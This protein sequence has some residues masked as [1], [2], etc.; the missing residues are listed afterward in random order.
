MLI[1]IE[2][3]HEN[4]LKKY[5]L[6]GRSNVMSQS[7]SY[8]ERI[9]IELL[10]QEGYSLIRI[11]ERL[12]R[13]R[14]SITREIRRGTADNKKDNL[15][16]PTK[17][18]KSMYR[19]RDAQFRAQNRRH[20]AG[21]PSSL[22]N[23][24]KQVLQTEIQQHHFTPGQVV[25]KH[26]RL[27]SNTTVIYTWIN[28][29][30]IPGLSNQDLPMQGKRYRRNIN[31][32]LNKYRRPLAKKYQ[33]RYRS[34]RPLVTP[35]EVGQYIGQRRTINE[36][37]TSINQR[38]TFG[39]W[40]MDGVESKNHQ[41]SLLITF[42]ERKTRYQ[43][44][45]KAKSK[46]ALEIVRVLSQFKHQYGHYVKSIT[47]DNGHE[48]VNSRVVKFILCY[49]GD[50]YV[51]NTYAPYERATNERTNRNLRARWYFPKGTLFS[52][53]TQQ[54]VNQVINEINS[55]PLTH[56]VKSQKSPNYLFKRATRRL[57]VTA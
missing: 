7:I 3:N 48:F 27:F 57:K 54:Q 14:S 9:K 6:K 20:H 41:G 13:N 29:N 16:Y 53:V 15:R 8:E 28:Q 34:F 40:E 46:S 11:A 10:I 24:K 56:A 37:P 39:H 42:V 45:I 47:C 30:K 32:A 19:A 51:A 38:R 44:A 5:D 21:R 17:L 49:L 2:T 52:D 33:R 50:L 22:T 36:R 23:Y 4:S 55:K 12:N 1:I 18:L 25:A 43:V 31:R 26:R 35:E